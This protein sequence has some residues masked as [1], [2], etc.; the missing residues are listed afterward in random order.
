[1]QA[2]Y[3]GSCSRKDLQAHLHS[4]DSGASENAGANAKRG[5]G[6]CIRTRC[7][8]SASLSPRTDRVKTS[9]GPTSFESKETMP[10][11]DS[12]LVTRYSFLFWVT[13]AAIDLVSEPWVA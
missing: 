1:G 6:Y 3:M 9:L 4:G 8:I 13:S 2:T 7:A 11:R 5:E 10:T 12:P